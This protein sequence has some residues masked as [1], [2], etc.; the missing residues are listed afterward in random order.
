MGGTGTLGQP[1]CPGPACDL[2]LTKDGIVAFIFDYVCRWM[3]WASGGNGFLQGLFMA[4]SCHLL[5][6]P[7]GQG[8]RWWWLLS[9]VTLVGSHCACVR[10]AQEVCGPFFPGRLGLG[11]LS[12]PPQ[13][14]R[15]WMWGSVGTPVLSLCRLVFVRL[16]QAR[17]IG[18][19]NLS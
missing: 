6:S 7:S 5:I 13:L 1:L 3:L 10:I 12:S 2:W 17:A 11:G 8:Q 4:L 14:E 18:K 9:A 16:I 19:D 15:K